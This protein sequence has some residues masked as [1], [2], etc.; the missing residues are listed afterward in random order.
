[1]AICI[2][3]ALIRVLSEPATLSLAARLKAL[4]TVCVPCLSTNS[5]GDGYSMMLP[6]R[7]A[8]RLD[9]VNFRQESGHVDREDSRLWGRVLNREFRIVFQTFR[10]L[11]HN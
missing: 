8:Q 6:I 10:S 11:R 9:L 2:N 7:C 5:C 4:I 1:M 3:T